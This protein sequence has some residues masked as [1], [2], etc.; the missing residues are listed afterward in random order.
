MPRPPD[1]RVLSS[2]RDETSDPLRVN[3]SP[4]PEAY[5][6]VTQDDSASLPEPDF[7]PLQ[8]LDEPE[9]KPGTDLDPYR[10]ESLQAQEALEAAVEA[11]AQGKHD[12][13]VQHYIRASKIA[14]TARE[15]HLAAVACQR[16]GDYLADPEGAHD[17]ERALRM[18]RRAVA[19]YER[20]GL[21]AEGRELSYKQMC[22]KM[23]RVKELRLPLYQRLELYLQWATAGFGYRPLRVIG[24]ALTVITLYALF[25]FLFG[26]VRRPGFEGRLPFS[27]CFYFSGITFATVGF[28]DF[29]PAEHMR[30]VA[31]SEGLVGAF[32]IGFFVAVLANRLSRA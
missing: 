16:V 1:S 30:L 26:G 18:Y 7:L 15:W 10:L 29:I 3:V 8:E 27:K 24:T 6:E 5:D 28:G 22:L 20:C 12:E 25:Y 17:L 23:R 2:E 9:D 11:T 19:A 31:L 14:E 4:H 21:F 32:V 13:A